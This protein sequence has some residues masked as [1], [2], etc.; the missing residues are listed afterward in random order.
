MKQAK[1]N[2]LIQGNRELAFYLSKFPPIEI[3]QQLKLNLSPETARGFENLYI[4]AGRYLDRFLEQQANP[5]P[6]SDLPEELQ[7]YIESKATFWL[8][9]GNLAFQA[10]K[11]VK[12][13]LENQ[14]LTYTWQSWADL[15]KQLILEEF[16]YLI[17]LESLDFWESLSVRSLEDS[18]R[19]AIKFLDD[20]ISDTVFKRSCDKWEKDKSKLKNLFNDAEIKRELMPWTIF[21]SQ[22]CEKYKKKLPGFL[23]WA[24][25]YPQNL[26]PSTKFA[27]VN[28]QL[29]KYPGRG[30]GK[31]K[32]EVS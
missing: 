27:I 15:N 8:L 31:A 18:S 7:T 9:Q 13:E 17:C 5:L 21:F 2:N 30:Q 3:W 23:P 28:G 12:A 16:K 10:E 6:D 22:T 29:K 32:Q 19:D 24:K 1:T 4:W 25:F 11:Y 14:G 20:S 26:P